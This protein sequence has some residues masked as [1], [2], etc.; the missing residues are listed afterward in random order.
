MRIPRKLKKKNKKK[1]LFNPDIHKKVFGLLYPKYT[2]KK[3]IGF[4]TDNCKGELKRCFYDEIVL[5]ESFLR[6]NDLGIQRID[7][8][9]EEVKALIDKMNN[10]N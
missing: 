7:P 9:S 3:M 5:G 6:V 8:L 10:E 1:G 2:Y 4:L